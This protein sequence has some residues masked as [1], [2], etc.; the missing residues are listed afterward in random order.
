VFLPHLITIVLV[1]IRD[2]LTQLDH[3]FAI[4]IAAYAIMSN[5]YHLV[6]KINP[7]TAENWSIDEVFDRWC[8]LFNGPMLVQQYRNG[9][10]LDT[11]QLNQLNHYADTYRERLSSL[12]WFMKCLNESIARKANAEDNCTGHFWESRFKS[13]ALLDEQAL[14]SCMAYVDLNPIRANMADTPEHSEFTSIQQ[15]ITETTQS[16][17]TLI[18]KLLGFA[19]RLDD[20]NAL[21][22]TLNDYIDLVDWSGRAIHTTKKGKIPDHLPSIFNRLGIQPEPF[23]NYLAKKERFNTVIGS[24]QSLKQAALHQGK[25]FFKGINAATR[26]YPKLT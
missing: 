13:Q 18:P 1:W 23:L 7:T 6:L 20:D 24:P 15:R 26:L 11:A 14:I 25:R 21:P 5:H 16:L 19:N 8:Q 3:S 22:F 10:Y 12:S 4:N 9:D 17:N 2:K